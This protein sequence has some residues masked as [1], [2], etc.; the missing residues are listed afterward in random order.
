MTYKSAQVYTGSEWV[1]IA[2]GVADS[3]Q[4]TVQNITG[5]SY[6]PSLADAGKALVFSN[7]SSVTLTIPAES[8]ANFTIGQTFVVVQKGTGAVTIAGAV[9]VTIRSKGNLLKT[10]GQY[11]EARLIKLASNEWLLS[12]DL[13]S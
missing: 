11:S 9:E 2:V 10:A 7:A 4:R 1:N 12:G 13:S 6:T 8:S 3:T 5:T